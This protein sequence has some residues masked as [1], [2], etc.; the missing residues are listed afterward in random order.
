MRH[1]EQLPFSSGYERPHEAMDLTP[2]MGGHARSEMQFA[3]GDREWPLINRIE[4]LKEFADATLSEIIRDT[5]GVTDVVIAGPAGY[6]GKKT[7]AEHLIMYWLYD[8]ENRQKIITFEKEYGRSFDISILTTMMAVH[9]AQ[10]NRGRLLHEDGTKKTPGEFTPPDAT[11]I[12]ATTIELLDEHAA[13]IDLSKTRPVRLITQ[14]VMGH[15]RFSTGFHTTQ[16]LVNRAKRDRSRVTKV[17]IPGGA[18]EIGENA[19]VSRGAAADA[20]NGEEVEEVLRKKK[21]YA[22]GGIP[23]PK[24]FVDLQGNITA[25]RKGIANA[26]Y[27]ALQNR[28]RLQSHSVDLRIPRNATVASILENPKLFSEIM[29][30]NA[31]Y[32]GRELLGVGELDLLV[33]PN[34]PLGQEKGPNSIRLPIYHI[35]IEELDIRK[36]KYEYPVEEE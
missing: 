5:D 13:K 28:E 36:K 29:T 7:I 3:L 27:L 26:V 32:F 14:L 4:G 17:I 34:V 18:L 20:E 8:F 24:S 23:D 1:S 25:V 12:D 15:P 33:A 10:Q 30:A 31:S 35:L 11:D 19:L 6:T 22:K 21:I 2:G 16:E 9:D